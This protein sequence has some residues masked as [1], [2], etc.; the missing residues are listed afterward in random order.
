MRA[1]DFL[2]RDTMAGGRAA[3]GLG[4]DGFGRGF[5]GWGPARRMG[6][7]WVDSDFGAG[8]RQRS[9]FR[10]HV[11][12]QRQKKRAGS[13]S[14]GLFWLKKAFSDPWPCA[15][16]AAL[17]VAKGRHT[18]ATRRPKATPAATGLKISGSP[19]RN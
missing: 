9:S 2:C 19:T 1:V 15:P 13:L 11:P 16:L 5:D 3:D 6:A 4:K 7:P 18:T 12:R 14:E 17:G 10:L 8:G